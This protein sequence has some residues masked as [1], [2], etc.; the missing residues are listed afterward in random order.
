M[1]KKLI[2]SDWWLP[3]AFAF[4]WFILEIFLAHANF[5]ALPSGIKS[6]FFAHPDAACIFI[7]SLLGRG[8]IL[9]LLFGLAL[10]LIEAAFQVHYRAAFYSLTILYLLCFLLAKCPSVFHIGHRLSIF[11]LTLRPFFSSTSIWMMSAVIVAFLNL[12]WIRSRGRELFNILGLIF[13]N[14]ALIAFLLLQVGQPDLSSNREPALANRASARP[15][16]IVILSFSSLNAEALKQASQRSQRLKNYMETSAAF[17]NVIAPSISAFESFASM[18]LA[19]EPVNSHLQSNPPVFD[20]KGT[21]LI[22]HSQLK[23]FKENGYRLVLWSDDPSASYLAD[24]NIFDEIQVKSLDLRTA[25]GPTVLSRWLLLGFFDNFIGRVLF[26]EISNRS[27]LASNNARVVGERVKNR[28]GEMAADQRP[29]LFI[30]HSQAFTDKLAQAAMP[31]LVDELDAPERAPASEQNESPSSKEISASPT[32]DCVECLATFFENALPQR[33]IDS[34]VIV[35]IV[36]LNAQSIGSGQIPYIER[37]SLATP[38]GQGA[39]LWIQTKANS[40]KSI[41]ARVSLVDLFPT[42]SDLAGIKASSTYPCDGISLLALI[43]GKQLGDRYLYSESGIW[44]RPPYR[45]FWSPFK[46]NMLEDLLT[47]SSVSDEGSGLF[48]LNGKYAGAIAVQK[49]REIFK[50]DFKLLQ[51]STS[52]GFQLVLCNVMTDIYCKKNLAENN[53]EIFGVFKDELNHLIKSELN[54]GDLPPLDF[55]KDA[56]LKPDRSLASYTDLLAAPLNPWARLFAGRALIERW[57]DYRSALALLDPLARDTQIPTPILRS[58]RYN[59]A[60]GCASREIFSQDFFPKF[61]ADLDLENRVKAYDADLLGDLTDYGSCSTPQKS[62][63]AYRKY[64]AL[65]AALSSIQQKNRGVR[66]LTPGRPSEIE[67][68]RRFVAHPSQG[69]LERKFL[70]ATRYQSVPEATAALEVIADTK[71]TRELQEARIDDL[72]SVPINLGLV[73]EIRA[74]YEIEVAWRSQDNLRKASLWLAEHLSNVYQAGHFV[75]FL[76]SSSDEFVLPARIQELDFDRGQSRAPSSLFPTDTEEDQRALTLYRVERF[77]CL[78]RD[79]LC[80][81]IEKLEA[82]YPAAQVL[83][84]VEALDDQARVNAATFDRIPG[85]ERVS[86]YFRWL[87]LENDRE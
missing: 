24:R 59:L 80:S 71:L 7:L 33:E 79:E 1:L 8:L 14:V 49:Q 38:I 20:P 32:I 39:G 19:Q 9:S 57:S 17:T 21:G 18:I 76:S 23:R 51:V 30:L 41:N 27:F 66:F 56:T 11:A 62:P 25:Y 54:N 83:R 61:I 22:Q 87:I 29:T 86:P 40:K 13:G 50:G 15:P 81:R 2:N 60:L 77:V 63:L 75:P 26:P 5:A 68:L 36:A 65:S 84:E 43:E 35:S 3:F 70:A 44:A 47:T 34:N 85:S 82:R 67:E 48:L 16:D 31:N 74:Y 42:L 55:A 45:D 64:Q 28:L 69:S 78:T 73:S 12:N 4:H 6:Q 10:F 53:P 37:T 72:F 46:P 52:L 58:A